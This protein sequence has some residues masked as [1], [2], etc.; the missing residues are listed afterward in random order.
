M[1]KWKLCSPTERTN[2]GVPL[3]RCISYWLV[4]WNCFLFFHLTW[5]CHH[6]NWLMLFRVGPPPTIFS[7]VFQGSSEVH[8]LVLQ[9]QH[10]PLDGCALDHGRRV[11]GEAPHRHRHG[12]H[13]A[14]AMASRPHRWLMFGAELWVRCFFWRRKWDVSWCM[15]STK[16]K[17]TMCRYSSKKNRAK[18]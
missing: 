5:E 11:A 1:V 7:L 4:V 17:M 6:P 12:G 18:I 15:Y 8:Q 16:W 2:W 10:V 9:P 13:G 3:C 14:A